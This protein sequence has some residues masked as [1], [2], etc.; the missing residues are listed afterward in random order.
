MERVGMDT[1]DG[2]DDGYVCRELRRERHDTIY[3]EDFMFILS[4]PKLHVRLT[5]V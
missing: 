2:M 3:G 4:L 5:V 1:N